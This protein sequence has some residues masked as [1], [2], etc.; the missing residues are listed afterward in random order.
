ML[1]QTR[2][3]SRFYLAMAVL[4]ALIA[5]VGFSRRY[6]LP[7]AA[8]TFQA[9]AIVHVHGIIT[10]GWMAFVVVQT[11]LVVRGRSSLHRRLGMAG[12][13]LGSLLIFTATE[14]TIL[15]LARELREGGPS[16]R[17]F[18]ATILG[19]ILMIASLFGLAIAYI[20]KP[21]VHKRLMLLT[22]F[23][24][25]RPALARIIQLLA[26]SL[27]R[28]DRNDLAGIASDALIVI[29]VVYDV[30]TRGKPHPVYIAGLAGIV[31]VQIATPLVRTTAVWYGITDW[32]AALA[33]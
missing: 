19:S 2:E 5:V 15:L 23:V 33:S 16:P 12:I 31:L 24:I 28:L 29:A 9:P 6:L 8:G 10:F 26:G 4:A 27:S 17:E 18:S 32:L 11:L 3:R 22:T 13:A 21:E 7:V 20:D 30:K 1:S 25:L 14:V